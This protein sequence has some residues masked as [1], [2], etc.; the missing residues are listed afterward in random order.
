VVAELEDRSANVSGVLQLGSLSFDFVAPSVTAE[1]L[2]GGP[3]SAG[4]TLRLEFDVSE[5]LAE[6]PVVELASGAPFTKGTSTRP[7]HH[8]YTYVA[9]GTESDAADGMAVR[10]TLV[11]AAG[12]GAGVAHT[13]DARATFD[14]RPPA[15]ASASAAYHPASG[16]PLAEVTKLGLGGSVRIRLLA[17]EPLGSA[18]VV[19]A[20]GSSW[21]V[22][23]V[24][25]EPP[26]VSYEFDARLTGSGPGQGPQ[27]LTV[28]L[29][30]AHGN[31]SAPL[32]LVVVN[33]D[34][35]PP[36]PVEPTAADL[37]LYRRVPWG[38]AAT[39]GAPRFAVEPTGGGAVVEPGAW[40]IF[41]DG[42]G[43]GAT[44]L[45]QV[46][47]DA[48]GALPAVELLAID[49]TAVHVAQL[50]GACNSSGAPTLL[51]NV[52]WTATLGGKVPGS[53]LENPFTFLSV[54]H[55]EDTL[56]QDA[57]AVSEADAARVATADT[58]AATRAGT[59]RWQKLQLAATGPDIDWNARM[60][61][62]AARGKVV[63]H[64]GGTT[65]YTT[66]LQEMWEWDGV[67][68][69]L[70]PPA[71]T[72]P[73]P[74]AGH[75][76]VYDRARDRVVIFGG[77]M[78]SATTYFQDL[79]EWDGATAEWTERSPSGAW[80]SART[81]LSMVYDPRR[82]KVIVFGGLVSILTPSAQNSP[83]Q[84]TWEWDGSTGAWTDLT[85]SGA[86][87]TAR[88]HAAAAWDAGR[89]RM[90]LFG[91][92]TGT[93]TTTFLDDTWE[94]N[95]STRTWTPFTPAHKPTVR[96]NAT[97]T[98]DARRG[99]V[100]LFGGQDGT[101]DYQEL[102]EWD[103]TDWT[104]PIVP[105]AG[106]SK[107]M[108]AGLAF[109]ELR[110]VSV[111]FGGTPRSV[112]TPASIPRDTWEWDGTRWLDMTPTGAKPGTR[113]GTASFYDPVRERVTL[114]GGLDSTGTKQETWVWQD[115]RFRLLAPATSAPGRF[116]ASIAFDTARGKALLYGGESSGVYHGYQETWEWDG[117]TWSGPTAAAAP[118]RRIQ[119]AMTYDPVRAKMLLFGGDDISVFYDDAWTFTPGGGWVAAATGPS[120]R[121]AP[122]MVYDAARDRTVLFGGQ[123]N[124]SSKWVTYQDTWTWDGAAWSLQTPAG[125]LPPPRYNHVAAYD[126]VRKKVLVFGGTIVPAV[127]Y[128]DLWEWD[129]AAWTDR[130][131]PGKRPIGRMEAAFVFDSKH[132]TGLLFGGICPGSNC[133]GSAMQDTWSWDGGATSRP[134]GLFRFPFAEAGAAGAT[135]QSVRVTAA[136]GGSGSG[137]TGTE[138]AAWDAGAW[139]V[140]AV[141]ADAPAAPG[142][143]EW[144][145][146]DPTTLHRLLVGPE[147]SLDVV[148]R[149]AGPNGEGAAQV[150]V[151]YAE[152]VFRY[153]LP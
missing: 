30:D 4:A 8:V 2:T 71:G 39:G 113:Y 11:D 66:S 116:R 9:T 127:A 89:D 42:A 97:A 94:W 124:V 58:V 34:T 27:S 152:A 88:G 54:P 128:D 50:D 104:G 52:E 61:Y 62:D 120:G 130:T 80:P 99:K 55:L 129:G 146:S 135:L 45:G 46:Q 123:A 122:Q 103:G 79:W 90:V 151:D 119:A 95:P 40:A 38:S 15:V 93:T 59:G 53:R 56:A 19:V 145:S 31:A 136:A 32:P 140:V 107:R 69:T 26:G 6:D 18:P 36:S 43:A 153:R 121:T 149:P 84:D 67:D 1:Q 111:L 72:E 16:C 5:E 12:N 73:P 92:L 134:G 20:P 106:P 108:R 96:A 28:T 13:L 33:V 138:L 35:A 74:R 14:F 70:R 115:R 110:G 118:P 137:A 85:G 65:F 64:R 44:V 17:D 125:P 75:G 3:A 105:A 49:R 132:G 112:P 144:T 68:W 22:T 41:T 60:A 91:G 76:L 141:N 98:Y 77:Q 117:A 47:A 86:K 87:P 48:A 150:A 57:A 37:L 147:R 133:S 143:V 109:D 102:W 131:P 23:S 142:K 7:L 24:S 83:Y 114:F 100:V 139:R 81:G 126:D 78:G 148:L 63:L 82:A 29:A 10:V 101:L 51:R 21:S 25:G